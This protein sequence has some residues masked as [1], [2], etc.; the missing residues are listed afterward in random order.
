MTSEQMDLITRKDAAALVGVSKRT[1]DRWLADG[2]LAKYVDGR[3][4]VWV[5]ADELRR[6][7]TP[8]P[9]TAAVR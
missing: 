8:R 1:L 2:R 4:F 5:D 7:T 6:L 9:V 3:G